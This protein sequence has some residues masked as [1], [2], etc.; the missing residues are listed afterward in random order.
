MTS[1]TRKWPGLIVGSALLV[2]CNASG[3]GDGP[4]RADS[5]PK[6]TAVGGDSPSYVLS[7]EPSGAQSVLAV[8]EQAKDG[9]EVVILGRIGGSDAPIVN[10]RLAFTIVDPSLKPCNEKNPDDDCPTP[11]NYS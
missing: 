6:T 5:G 4:R 7:R 11:W 10:G 8:R 2:G 9:E 3:P 1:F